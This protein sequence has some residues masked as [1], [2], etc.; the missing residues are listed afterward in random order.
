MTEQEK[1]IEILEIQQD[2]RLRVRFGDKERL[3]EVPPGAGRNDLLMH[4]HGALER[5]ILVEL[6]EA[7]RFKGDGLYDPAAKAADR[8]GT[9]APPAFAERVI[10]FLAPKNSVQALLGDLHEMFRKNADRLGEQEARRKYRMQ[11]AAS[12]V[13]LLWHWL[14]RIGFFTVLVDYFRSKLGL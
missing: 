14:K 4:I 7:R 3:I 12:L 6:K 9:L 2:G 13:P 10:S 11:V 5:Q 1:L 8:T